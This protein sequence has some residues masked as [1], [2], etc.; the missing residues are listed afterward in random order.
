M[1]PKIW[2]QIYYQIAK[3]SQDWRH[4]M[5]IKVVSEFNVGNTLGMEKRLTTT[6]Q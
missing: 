1:F 4:F 3:I 5:I 6:K 2:Y